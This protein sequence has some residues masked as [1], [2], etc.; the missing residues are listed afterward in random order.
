MKRFSILILFISL[1]ALPS[2]S[3]T[4]AVNNTEHLKLGLSL[5]KDTFSINEDIKVILT[6]TNAGKTEQ[7]VLFDMP[8][9]D[10]F[11]P[12]NTIISLQ[13]FGIGKPVLKYFPKRALESKTYNELELKEYYKVLE[14]GQLLSRKYSLDNL[15]VIESPNGKLPKGSYTLRVFYGLV[16]SNSVSF[17]IN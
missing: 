6:L 14:P 1:T 8:G 4:F 2:F 7:R 17:T 9:S 11:G 10:L 16:E 3:Q 15:A 5:Q 12:A 13:H